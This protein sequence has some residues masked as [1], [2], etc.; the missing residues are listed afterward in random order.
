MF[1]RLFL[2]FTLGPM[3]ELVILLRISRE[4]GFMTTV[5]IV[6]LTGIAG[7]YLARR[8]GIKALYD[9]RASMARGEMP[10]NALLNGF[11]VLIAGALLVTPGILTDI[12]GFVLLIPYTRNLI[13]RILIHRIRRAMRRGGANVMY[14]M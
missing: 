8:E 1:F 14:R 5:T 6:L 13:R 11:L 4:I 9:L 7:A 2:L 12:V 10:G 3:I